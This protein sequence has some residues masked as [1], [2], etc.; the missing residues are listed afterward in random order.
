ML[1]NN[2]QNTITTTTT[3]TINNLFQT[4]SERSRKYLHLVLRE[5]PF[6]QKIVDELKG[7]NRLQIYL[8]NVIFPKLEKIGPSKFKD[9]EKSLKVIIILSIKEVMQEMMKENLL[10]LSLEDLH[11]MD[12][13]LDDGENHEKMNEHK[14]EESKTDKKEEDKE[15]ALKKVWNKLF[16]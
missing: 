9:L 5:K 14:N 2:N 15:N 3:T 8:Q 4:C 13:I 6:A 1:S 12:K 10:A 7:E 11:L 16:G